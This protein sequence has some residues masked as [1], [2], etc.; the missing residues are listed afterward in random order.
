MGQTLSQLNNIHD[1]LVNDQNNLNS[2]LSGANNQNNTLNSN[3]ISLNKK[4]DQTMQN[5][6]VQEDGLRQQIQTLQG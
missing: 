3:L 2:Q 6:K 1:R 5:Y 4:Y